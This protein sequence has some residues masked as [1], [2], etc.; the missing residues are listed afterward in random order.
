MYAK[1]RK[2]TDNKRSCSKNFEFGQL[3]VR[4][5]AGAGNGWKK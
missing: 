2:I 5:L 4:V 1:W 3:N